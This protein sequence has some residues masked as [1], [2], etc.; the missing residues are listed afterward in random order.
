MKPQAHISSL[1]HFRFYIIQ[2]AEATER[3]QKDLH[4][5]SSCLFPYY[6]KENKLGD[7]MH[8]L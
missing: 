2:P 4:S 5:P 3:T 7:Q 1:K 8:A 6:Q